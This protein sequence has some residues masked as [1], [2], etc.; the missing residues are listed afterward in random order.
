MNPKPMTQGYQVTRVATKTNIADITPLCTFRPGYRRG[1]AW[2]K[3]K[4]WKSRG[5]G[6][7]GGCWLWTSLWVS[8]NTLTLS[9]FSLPLEFL[10]WVMICCNAFP[11]LLF[12]AYVCSESLPILAGGFAMSKQQERRRDSE[13]VLIRAFYRQV[14]FS[15]YCATCLLSQF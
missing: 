3:G 9:Q 1:S 13:M 8:G 5:S 11:G 7:F 12:P 4:W 2:A 15:L 10:G 14:Y 6:P